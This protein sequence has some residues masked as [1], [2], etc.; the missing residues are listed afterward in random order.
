MKV[1]GKALKR[2]FGRVFEGLSAQ[3][4]EGIVGGLVIEVFHKKSL[5]L[6]K[7]LRKFQTNSKD[8]LVEF[9][10]KFSEEF[11]DKKTDEL[12]SVFFEANFASNLEVLSGIPERFLGE[13]NGNF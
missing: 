11:L 4:F 1:S 7:F 2:T 12:S 9:S 6:K 3:T 5:V 10:W 13:M 8:L